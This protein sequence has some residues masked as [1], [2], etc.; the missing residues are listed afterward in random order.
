MA[1]NVRRVAQAFDARMARQ[2]GCRKIGEPV[3]EAV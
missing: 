3:S 2:F 1:S